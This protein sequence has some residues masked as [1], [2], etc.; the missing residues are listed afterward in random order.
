MVVDVEREFQSGLIPQNGLLPS[1]VKPEVIERVIGIAT[2]LGVEGREGAP[3]GTL[4]VIGDTNAIRH[5]TKPLIL[6]PFYGYKEEDRNILNPFMDETIKELSLIDGAFVLRGDGVIE[7][8]GTMIYASGF[9]HQLPGGLGTRHTSA[10]AISMAV[11]C[12]AIT[13]SSS[14]GQVTLFR[15]GEMIPLIEKGFSRSI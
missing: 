1:G 2:E 10:A 7:S 5:Y 13:V 15:K 14:S 11:D 12:V 4:F 8:A 3:V 9:Y 6:N